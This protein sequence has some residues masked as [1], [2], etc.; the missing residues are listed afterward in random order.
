MDS[1]PTTSIPPTDPNPLLEG[2]PVSTHSNHGHKLSPRA[3]LHLPPLH[4]RA[5]YG[6]G[7]LTDPPIESAK[8]RA[9][10]VFT[11]GP[12]CP[13][14]DPY[15]ISPSLLTPTTAAARRRRRSFAAVLAKPA[16][17]RIPLHLSRLEKSTSI[18]LASHYRELSSL[19]RLSE[20]I[21]SSPPPPLPSEEEAEDKRVTEEAEE[22][23]VEA[24]S[25]ITTRLALRIQV[26]MS[27][28]EH[29]IDHLEVIR[30]SMDD[31]SRSRVRLLHRLHRLVDHESLSSSHKTTKAS[32]HKSSRP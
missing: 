16:L 17:R 8:E 1:P 30:S 3:S 5:W 7:L 13:A 28:I 31:V 6:P 19:Q 22:E 10:R 29:A 25:I 26:R 23:D 24:L 2:R 14:D 9:E 27:L 4:P 32:H 12:S 11:H 18:I 21:L 15:R 20:A